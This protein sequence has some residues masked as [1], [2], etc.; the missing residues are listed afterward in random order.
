MLDSVHGV[1]S[2]AELLA[3][4]IWVFF[5]SWIHMPAISYG[6]CQDYDFLEGTTSLALWPCATSDPR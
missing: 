5:I 6:H 1:F 4:H 3:A 2:L